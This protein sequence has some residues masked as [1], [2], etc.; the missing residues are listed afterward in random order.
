VLECLAQYKT[1]KLRTGAQSYHS[2][3]YT[4]VNY[5]LLPAPELEGRD[6]EVIRLGGRVH[7]PATSIVGV[8]GAACQC[9]CEVGPAQGLEK[10]QQQ[11]KCVY[12]GRG[13]HTSHVKYYTLAYER[14]HSL[15]PAFR[16]SIHFHR[17][18]KLR[19]DFEMRKG[20]GTCR[21]TVRQSNIEMSFSAS[22]N[23]PKLFVHTEQ[24]LCV[25]CQF[26]TDTF[27]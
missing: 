22:C 2:Y 16:L 9:S 19:K 8:Q 6:D 11:M 15:K 20:A 5:P 12:W 4:T 7:F 21:P 27:S 24:C 18:T 14:C 1:H 3:V 13:K 17:E 25:N 10:E 23:E 26:Y